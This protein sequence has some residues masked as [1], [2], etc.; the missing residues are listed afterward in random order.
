MSKF[1]NTKSN[2]LYFFESQIWRFVKLYDQNLTRFEIFISK[3]D[4]LEKL[5][6]K[7]EKF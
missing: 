3:S 4:A 5:N 6:S 1:F 7:F 2:A